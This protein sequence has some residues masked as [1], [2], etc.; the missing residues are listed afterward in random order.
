MTQETRWLFGTTLVLLAIA[1]VAARVVAARV[2]TEAGRRTAK[3]LLDRTR[4]WWVMVAVFFAAL[5]L[6]PR[7][8]FLM[9]AFLSFVA[10]REFVT[11]A[12]TRR[13][14]HRTLFW[15]FF[16]LLPLHY[17]TLWVAWYNLFVILI[18]VYGFL[19][20]PVRNALAGDTERYL[21][22]TAVVQWGMMVCVYCLSHAPALLTLAIPGFSPAG[23]ARLLFFLT[24][25]AQFSDVMQYVF[26]KT[27]GRTPVAPKLSPNKTWEGLLGGGLAASLGGAA[28]WWS[29]PF[30]PWQAGAMA[31]LIVAMG[32]F[33]GLVM[34]AI[35]RDRGVKD[36]G[37]LIPGHGGA[38]DRIDSLCFAAPVF[39]HATRYWF[40]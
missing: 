12:P 8:T 3:N 36:W 16:I 28:L 7:A 34:S 22:R 38:L 37:E 14:D 9:F 31:A 30:N 2:S 1:S 10:L 40:T 24:F 5:A 20:V 27:L 23:N 33:G 6:G 32:F 17:A 39:F 19:L 13:G 26:G 29:T 21:E 15:A 4:A 11:L 25:V 18:P 35:K